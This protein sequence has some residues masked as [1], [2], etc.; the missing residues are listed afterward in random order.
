MGAQD[1]LVRGA[2]GP[3]LA[4]AGNVEKP[5]FPKLILGVEQAFFPLGVRFSNRKRICT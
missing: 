3:V 4:D 5:L 2:Q 1:V